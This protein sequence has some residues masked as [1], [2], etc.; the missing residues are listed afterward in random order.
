MR[1]GILESPKSPRS[2]S[3]LSPGESK[4]CNGMDMGSM[5]LLSVR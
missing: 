1:M 4:I 3:R 5:S 2:S